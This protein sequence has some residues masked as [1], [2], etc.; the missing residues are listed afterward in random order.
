MS[1]F[2]YYKL[3]PQKIDKL[4]LFQVPNDLYPIQIF[5]IIYMLLVF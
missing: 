2:L 4:Q 1:S 3:D 5:Y